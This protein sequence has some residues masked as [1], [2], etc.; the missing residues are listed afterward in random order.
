MRKLIYIYNHDYEYECMII[1]IY[2]YIYVYIY[3][4]IVKPVHELYTGTKVGLSYIIRT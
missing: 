1:Y 4:Y 2:I 3:I